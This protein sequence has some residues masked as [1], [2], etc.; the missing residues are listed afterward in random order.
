MDSLP[1]SVLIDQKALESTDQKT[2]G[3]ELAGE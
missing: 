2:S 1:S 3:N